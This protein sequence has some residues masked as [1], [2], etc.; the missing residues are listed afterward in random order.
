MPTDASTQDNHLELLGKTADEVDPELVALPDPPRG[1]RR[2]TVLVLAVTAIASVAMV[3]SLWRDAAYALAADRETDLGDLKSAPA[4]SFG[5]NAFVQARGMLGAAGAIRYERPFIEDSFRVAP[6]AGRPDVYV[7]MRVPN[8][9]ET[10]R[11]VPPTEFHGRLLRFDAVGPRHRGLRGAIADRTGT[12]VP[13][14]AWLLVSGEAPEQAR[15]AVALVLLFAGFAAWNA[16][17]IAR[18]LRRV[19]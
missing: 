14:N 16:A 13:A 12:P 15:W 6:V 3:L 17:A 18:L 1:E 11:Y 5:P 4:G 8:G 19:K 10:A 9:E 2:A 7:E